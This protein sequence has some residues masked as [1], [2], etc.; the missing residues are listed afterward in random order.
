MDP[1]PASSSLPHWPLLW[2]QQLCPPSSPPSVSPIGPDPKRP[3]PK[4]E[5]FVLGRMHNEVL[6]TLEVRRGQVLTATRELPGRWGAKIPNNWY[7]HRHRMECYNW[8]ADLMPHNLHIEKLLIIKHLFLKRTLSVKLWATLSY[9]LRFLFCT[10]GKSYF[11]SGKM[12]RDYS[13]S[14]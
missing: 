7:Q 14:Y 11:K 3:L 4:W 8:I 12:A 13:V 5:S 9:C 6:E 10:Y 1:P 2:P